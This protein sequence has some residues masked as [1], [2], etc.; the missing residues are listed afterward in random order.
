M[1][2]TASETNPN[3]QHVLNDAYTR[4]WL[5]VQ[6]IAH[7]QGT[8]RRGSKLKPILYDAV[9]LQGR[10]LKGISTP[11]LVRFMLRGDDS[12]GSKHNM[13]DPYEA[14]WERFT[15]VADLEAI[16]KLTPKN[17]GRKPKQKVN[18]APLPRKGVNVTIKRKTGAFS[19]QNDKLA[20]NIR[21]VLIG[22][23]R[24]M[25]AEAFGGEA[26]ISRFTLSAPPR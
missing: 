16:D 5:G 25:C 8:I 15:S 20:Q 23:A 14:F 22:D 26:A 11:P 3:Y 9:V 1:T 7:Y 12:P 13:Q 18:P 24:K 17:P 2:D 6:P 4:D 21:R 19:P 10:H